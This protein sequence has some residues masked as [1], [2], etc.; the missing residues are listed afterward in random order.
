MVVPWPWPWCESVTARLTL[1][2]VFFGILKR[3]YINLPFRET[4]IGIYLAG[5]NSLMLFRRRL[6]I[7]L[8]RKF[9]AEADN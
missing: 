8:L 2:F 4:S 1:K 6:I 5:F 3:L 7:F 9:I